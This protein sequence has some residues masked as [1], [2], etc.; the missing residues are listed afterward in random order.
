M[1]IDQKP[2]LLEKHS[3]ILKTKKNI[4]SIVDMNFLK[5]TNIFYDSNDNLQRCILSHSVIF[6]ATLSFDFI[7]RS[8]RKLGVILRILLVLLDVAKRY[9]FFYLIFTTLAFVLSKTS[10]F[11]V[12]YR[13]LKANRELI[14]A[15]IVFS[16]CY[17]TILETYASFDSLTDLLYKLPPIRNQICDAIYNGLTSACYFLYPCVLLITIRKVI[18]EYLNY[19]IHYKFLERRILENDRLTDSMHYLNKYTRQSTPTDISTWARH[20]FSCLTKQQKQTISVEDFILI[21]GEQEGNSL[22]VLFDINQNG[23]IDQEEFVEVYENIFEERTTLRKTLEEKSKGLNKLGT[24]IITFIWL[25]I[26]ILFLLSSAPAFSRVFEIYCLIIISSLYIISP[27]II[28]TINSIIYIFIVHPYDINDDIEINKTTYTVKNIGI[29][30][31][32]VDRHGE[33]LTLPNDSLRKRDIK[34]FKNVEY[35][36]FKI[37]RQIPTNTLKNVSEYKSRIKKYLSESKTKFKSDFELTNLEINDSITT[38]D[39][40]IKVNSVFQEPGVVTKRRDEIV[41][42]LHRLESALFK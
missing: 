12:Q 5:N 10:S 2:G 11:K 21:F 6:I 25:I 37:R 36:I 27:L 28:E 40:I 16:I 29:L 24:L 14:S 26:L 19:R 4:S 32:D 1:D 8:L 33:V 23:E 18:L 17:F 39:V 15:C 30:Y 22:F 7:I 9:L 42:F 31:T 41:I 13:L 20:V 35:K 3:S 34:S 38:F